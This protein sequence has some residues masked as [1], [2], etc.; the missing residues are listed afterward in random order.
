VT[1]GQAATAAVRRSVLSA[2]AVLG[3]AGGLHAQ[4][5]VPSTERDTTAAVSL[6]PTATPRDSAALGGQRGVQAAR[7][8]TTSQWIFRGFLGGVTFGPLGAGVAYAAAN[9]SGVALTPQY[10]MLLLQEGGAAY[11]TAYQDAYAE[12]LRARRKRAAVTGGVLGTAALAAVVTTVWA[13][14]YYY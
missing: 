2:L 14:Y 11:A 6:A 3:A 10:R 8:E 7:N 9:N 4:Q 1:G 12:S 5:P 13:I